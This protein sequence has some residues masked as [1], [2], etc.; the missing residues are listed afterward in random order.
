MTGICIGT[1]IS[2]GILFALWI[3]IAVQIRIKPYEDEK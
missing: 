2:A 1:V 3:L